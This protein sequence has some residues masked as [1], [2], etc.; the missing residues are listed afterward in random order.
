M[1]EVVNSYVQALRE[2]KARPAHNLKQIG[3][4]WCTP[5]EI[6]WGISV[7]YG[8]FTLDLF[9]DA[10][11]SKCPHF[12]HAEDNAL[13]QDWAAKLQQVGGAA[14]ANPP[15]SRSTQHKGQYL[16]GVKHIINHAMAMR[17]KGGRYVFLLKAATS[18][19]WWP[20]QADHIAFIRGR[21]GFD[22]PTWFVPENEKQVS[23]GAFFAAAIVVFDKRWTGASTGYV[24][25]DDLIAQGKAFLA[26]T[27][28]IA[29]K[30][31]GVA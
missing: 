21:I 31:L 27:K 28:W 24:K 13:V 2:L 20:E 10:Q 26:Q 25:R 30:W 7:L 9:S 16:T 5:E 14:F 19:I 1:A 11:N 4:E 6:F 15:Y 29:E 23:T 12:Y 17:D 18:E 8:P 3:D 22:V